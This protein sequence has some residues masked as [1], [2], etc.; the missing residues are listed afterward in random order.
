MTDEQLIQ[1]KTIKYLK[2][3]QSLGLPLYFEKRQAGGFSYKMG[4]PDLYFVINGYHFE[5]EFKT[6]TKKI[7]LRNT[8]L[9]WLK[10]F[11]SINVPT[12]IENDWLTIKAFIDNAIVLSTNKEPLKIK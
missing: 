11:N 8:Q 10:Y 1:N 6:S 7:Q 5:I 12:I 3:Q 9:Y 4:L 2:K